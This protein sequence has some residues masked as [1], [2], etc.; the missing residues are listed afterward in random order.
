MHVVKNRTLYLAEPIHDLENKNGITKFV[1][2]KDGSVRYFTTVS[3]EVMV[4]MPPMGKVPMGASVLVEI[5]ADSIENAFD[6]IPLAIEAG[7]A[8]IEK[9]FN[10]AVLSGKMPDPN[11]IPDIKI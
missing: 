4:T 9:E 6:R 7:R 2:L 8:A 11:N 3:H 5:E 10:R 1:P